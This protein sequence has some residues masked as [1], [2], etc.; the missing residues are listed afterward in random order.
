MHTINRDRIL[1]LINNFSKVKI[2]VLGDVMLDEFIWGK[3]TRISPEAPVPVVSV[4]HETS[5]PGGAANVA[6][7]IRALKSNVILAGIVGD[8]A[9][10]D[11]LINLLKKDKV[12]TRALIKQNG[13]D[14]I[15]KTRVIAHSQQVVRIDKE[16]NAIPDENKIKQ[17]NGRLEKV[18]KNI[19]GVI[20]EDY[21][22]GLITQDL[23]YYLVDICRRNNKPLIVDPKKGHAID[24]TGVTLLTPNME[25]ALSL[26]GMD[27]NGEYVPNDVDSAGRI[28]M[29]RWGLSGLLI[30]LGEHGMNLIE[31]NG[32]FFKIP[33]MAQEVYDVSGAGDTVAGVFTTALCAGATM[34]ESAFIANVAAGIVV[35]KVGT[36]VATKEELQE[37]V[38][39]SY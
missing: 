15:L 7:N 25:E 29:E 21:G 16:K 36:A 23:V 34:K 13:Y 31:K 2:L 6:R 24:Y 14:T 39:N 33:T 4:H 17:L 37:G 32:A 18:I 11:R 9:N 28:I 5:M 1:K 26:A 10:A 12:D 38:K 30:T 20:M 3:V 8:D 35:G 19:D 22:K 27:Y